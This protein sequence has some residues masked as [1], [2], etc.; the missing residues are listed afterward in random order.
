MTDRSKELRPPGFWENLVRGRFE[1]EHD[2]ALFVVDSLYLDFDERIR[3]YRNGQLVETAR[4]RASWEIGGGSRIEAEVSQVGMKYARF[5]AAGSKE[6]ESLRPS[7]G[8]PEA[9]R[10][11]VDR[12][13]PVASRVTAIAAT[14][15]LIAVLLIEIPQLVNLI[16]GWA[17]FR[18][19]A[20]ELPVWINVVLIVIAA[21][22]AI[23]RSL[24]MRY[25]PL[26][27]D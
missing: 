2:G 23:E 5:R 22:A 9:W 8:T 19:P 1:I 4:R 16:G 20:L 6:T 14:V 15:A 11:K 27:D 17:N 3:L 7:P 13:H 24:S 26:L 12:T 25:N 10:A 21:A 18:V